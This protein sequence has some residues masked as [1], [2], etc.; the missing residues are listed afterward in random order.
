TAEFGSFA[1]VL[2]FALSIAQAGL[3][4]A[5]RMRG[6]TALAGAGEGAAVGAFIC[7]ACAFAALM[8]AFVTSDFSVMNV[9]ENSHTAKPLLYK[10][11][12]VWGSHEGSM[13]LWCLML[14]GYGAV[15]A[16]AGRLPFG[17]KASALATQGLLGVLFIG[18]M[19]FASNPLARV[20][21][22]PFQGNSLNPLLQDPALAGHPPFLYSGY[23]GFSV[24]FSLSVAA[25]V[26]GR[27]DPAW[28]RWIRPWTLAA[29]SL[30][31]I[32]ITLGSYWAYYELGWGGWWAWDPVENA[33][34]MPWL[35]GTALLHSA[36]VTEKRG[37]LAS[38]TVLLGIGAF[39]L[40]M[41]GAFLVRSGVL[42]SVHAFAIDPKRGVLLLGILGIAA[43]SALALYAWRAPT[44]KD[45]AVFAPVSREG[46]LFLNNVLLAA[47]TA[48]VLI[49]TLL[50][51]I[52]SAIDGTPI[53]VGAPYYNLTFTAL[54]APALIALPAGALLA[55]KRGDLPVALRRLWIAA[56][57]AAVAV[58][59]TFGL[60][61]PRSL[62]AACGIGLG[63][64]VIVGALVEAA[65]R[66][67]LFRAPAPEVG[68]RALGLPRGA[69]G[70][71]LAHIGIGVFALGAA[72]ETA[73]R[74][75]ATEAL[76]VGQSLRLGGYTLR[77]DRV[78]QEFGPNFEAE[79]AYIRV[80]DPSG[81]VLCEAAPDRRLYAAGGQTISGVAICPTLLDDA[82]VVF[83]DKR[84][85]SPAGGGG[86]RS[87]G[88]GSSPS[89]ATAGAPQSP[90]G[91]TTR[92]LVP[93]PP[94]RGPPPPAG[95]AQATY[96]VRAYWNPWVRFV[97]AGP[98]IMA[99]G[100]LVSLTDR[101]LR[102]AVTA[103][104]RAALA[105][106]AAE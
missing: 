100:G 82:Y 58:L 102:F 34:F 98:L 95:E 57:A 53:S 56:L 51:L 30:L 63:V 106:A 65:E 52:R 94:L 32:G 60:V 15:M 8:F 29:W 90:S 31:T 16:A 78:A 37:G 103:K 46:A 81:A 62:L 35:M 97:F 79:R 73:W 72:F 88:G 48:V 83:G 14:T 85:S 80:T 38:W 21:D 96:L 10:I 12:G 1:L 45:E 89:S 61:T 49:G 54:V 77:L 64:W 33:S 28:A 4:V 101:R 68:R 66:V 3:A 39:T 36:A 92:A 23:V 70:M 50:P 75:E 6:S 99:L 25:L 74:A 40:S 84:L 91:S 2:A 59:A 7:T 24:V 67:R 42:T 20:V 69:W 104:V 86:P 71:T 22:A 27:V 18:Y 19:V 43:G 105:P 13:L 41:M 87:G 93:P 17:L 76:T 9:A 11:T 5:G 26:E 47:A 55:W 44:L